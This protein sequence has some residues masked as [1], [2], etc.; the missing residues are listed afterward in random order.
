[1]PRNSVLEFSIIRWVESWRMITQLV[2]EV[3]A[4]LHNSGLKAVK[5]LICE[6]IAFLRKIELK[7]SMQKKM[8]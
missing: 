2:Y 5:L 8:S 6:V 1:M 4:S 7:K 3:S